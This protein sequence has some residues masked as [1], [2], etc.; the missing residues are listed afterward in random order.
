MDQ[1]VH[2]SSQDF[3]IKPN[4]I[5]AGVDEAGRGCLAGPVVAAAVILG[6]DVS[7][8]LCQD[9]KQVSEKAREEIYTHIIMSSSTIGIGV[10][11][12]RVIDRLNILQATFRAMAFAIK[13]LSLKPNKVLVDGNRVPAN[14]GI[15]AEA[16]VKGD[17]LIPAISAASIIAKVT[18]D[19][20][21]KRVSTTFSHYQ[22]EINKGYGTDAHYEGLFTCGPSPIHRR[23]FNLTRQETLF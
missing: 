3:L 6:Q 2:G 17:R 5:I 11:S 15:E 18:R 10:V 9:S 19:R 8:Q 1:R 12:H 20:I 7:H 13:R 16:I 4:S 21:M 22:F 23:S 14:L